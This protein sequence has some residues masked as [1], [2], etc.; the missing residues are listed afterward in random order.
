[1]ANQV[2]DGTVSGRKKQKNRIWITKFSLVNRPIVANEN[3]RISDT[4]IGKQTASSW[5]FK[6]AGHFTPE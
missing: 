4:T 6:T 5:N 3:L 1:M 2:P